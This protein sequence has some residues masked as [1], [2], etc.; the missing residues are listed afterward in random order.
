[1]NLE[2]LQTTRHPG[3]VLKKEIE[4]RGLVKSEVARQLGI[5]PGHLSE[6]F[7]GKRNISAAMALKLQGMLK[8]SAVKWL[9]LQNLYD[10]SILENRQD[11]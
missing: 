9:G 3:E 6:L 1:M 11:Q 4:E 7:K 10:L 5:K 8:I 2:F